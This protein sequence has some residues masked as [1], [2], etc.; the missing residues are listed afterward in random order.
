[1]NG[2]LAGQTVLLLAAFL[3]ADAPPSFPIDGKKEP[4]A[5]ALK[6]LGLWSDQERQKFEGID[7]DKQFPVEKINDKGEPG[8]TYLVRGQRLRDA[9]ALVAGYSRK[10]RLDE[11]GRK[12]L[13][14]ALYDTPEK[15]E[16]AD[17]LNAGLEKLKEALRLTSGRK[18]A[19][20]DGK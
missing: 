3:N 13:N 14:Q 4:L 12:V 15:P 2:L 18:L 11:E 20:L 9:V 5:A 16:D 10:K 19:E 7:P 8:D 1:M 17:R 6:R